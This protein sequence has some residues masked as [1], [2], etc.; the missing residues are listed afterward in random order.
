MTIWMAVE[1]ESDI[2]DLVLE[3]FEMWGI[4]GIAFDNATDTINWLAK[5]ERQNTHGELPELA[6]LDIRL[7]DFSGLE[8]SMAIRGNKW[9]HNIPIALMTA[10]HLSAEEEKEVMYHSQADILIYKP[11]P[12][13]VELCQILEK[14]VHQRQ[15]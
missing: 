11:L 9:L 4:N 1:D 8:I 10:Y 12:G 15:S 14:V 3:M 2:Y 13:M 6:L 5:I 7:P